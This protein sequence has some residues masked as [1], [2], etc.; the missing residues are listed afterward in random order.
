MVAIHPMPVPLSLRTWSKEA[1][2]QGPHPPERRLVQGRGWA[3]VLAWL[4]VLAP[5]ATNNVAPE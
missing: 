1:N 5:T 2:L 4:L 3:L